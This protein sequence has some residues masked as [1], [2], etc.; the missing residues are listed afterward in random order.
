MIEFEQPESPNLNI[1]VSPFLEALDNRRLSVHLR[2]SHA[3]LITAYGLLHR[4]MNRALVLALDA[5]E[6]YEASRANEGFNDEI[7]G[8]PSFASDAFTDAVYRAAELFEFYDTDI[9]D[10]LKPSLNRDVR[11]AYKAALKRI[12]G[13]WDRLCNGFKHNHSF[14]VPVEGQYA[15]GVWL[16]GYSVYRH[17]SEEMHIDKGIHQLSDVLSYNWAF[18]RLIGSI[19][20]ADVTATMLLNTLSDDQSCPTIES[21]LLPLPYSHSLPRISVRELYAFPG[22]N[23]IPVSHFSLS[24]DDGQEMHLANAGPLVPALECKLRCVV[25]FTTAE[26]AVQQ[27]YSGEVARFSLTRGEGAERTPLGGFYRIVISGLAVPA[28][29]VTD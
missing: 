3:P 5:V 14:M 13:P 2:T 27:P 10:Y 17:E 26:M 18:R 24:A 20:E 8:Q 15:D 22:E 9:I 6:K 21:N 19:I 16:S 4:R 11:V 1:F 29:N 25:E 23:K 7:T 12:S 28:S